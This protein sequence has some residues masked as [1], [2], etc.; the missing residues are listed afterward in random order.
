MLTI[1]PREPKSSQLRSQLNRQQTQGSAGPTPVVDI[2]LPKPRMQRELV[3]AEIGDGLLNLSAFA[4]E[5]DPTCTE[6][7]RV[8]HVGE[9]LTSYPEWKPNH[10]PSQTVTYTCTVPAGSDTIK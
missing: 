9:P 4:D 3:T 7:W 10:K 2:V 6:L 5:C 1:F 8:G